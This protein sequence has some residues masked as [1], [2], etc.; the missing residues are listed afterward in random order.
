[1]LKVFIVLLFILL[2]SLISHYLLSKHS[3]VNSKLNVTNYENDKLCNKE[4]KDIHV[5]LKTKE[6]I[7]E[8]KPIEITNSV[9]PEIEYA[10]SDYN[11]IDKSLFYRID[12]SKDKTTMEHIVRGLFTTGEHAGKDY[13]TMNVHLVVTNIKTGEEVVNTIQTYYNVVS[14]NSEYLF[15]FREVTDYCTDEF[16]FYCTITAYLDQSNI[17]I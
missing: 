10:V 5:D 16:T 17:N 14:P 7:I 6:M 4:I 1:M 12:G 3:G 15:G 11:I 13:N 9:E 8:E 2:G